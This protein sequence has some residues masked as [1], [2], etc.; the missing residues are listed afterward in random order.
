MK[1]SMFA[2]LLLVASHSM[3]ATIYNKNCNVYLSGGISSLYQVLTDKGY[4]IIQSNDMQETLSNEVNPGD[5]VFSSAISSTKKG[6]V[7]IER[8]FNAYNAGTN[9]CSG[10]FN[11]NSVIA[12][13]GSKY[14]LLSVGK[15]T[16]TSFFSLESA[17]EDT[18]E[19]LADLIPTCEIR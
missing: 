12:K 13:S 1:I 9:S 17:C 2:L 18:I 11:I 8:D 7:V 15:S 4:H 16:N 5:L 19:E 6:T 10:A 3:A 14:A